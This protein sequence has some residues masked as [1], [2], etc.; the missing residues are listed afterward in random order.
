MSKRKRQILS[1][2]ERIYG[3]IGYLGGKREFEEHKRG[4]WRI[5]ERVLMEPRRCSKART[6][7]KDI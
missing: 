5:W 4:N 1:M 2:L 7:K 3:R 6:G